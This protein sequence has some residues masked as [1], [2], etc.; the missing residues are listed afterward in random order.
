MI[1]NV[2]LDKNNIISKWE[3]T[4]IVKDL[5]FDNHH[6]MLDNN[7]IN[8]KRN[9]EKYRINKYNKKFE[10]FIESRDEYNIPIHYMILSLGKAYTKVAEKVNLFL[11]GIS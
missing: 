1:K 10:L 7:K 5:K 9:S 6:I 3:F 11:E 2:L 4:T 8:F